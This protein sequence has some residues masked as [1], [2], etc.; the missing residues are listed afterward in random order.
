MN[1]LKN[2]I[3]KKIILSLALS[4]L[5]LISFA[6]KPHVN[7]V[8]VNTTNSTVKWTGSKI[9]D[10]HEGSINIKSGVLDFDHGLL[11]GGN[12][13]IDMN[14]ILCTDIESEKKN[15]YFVTHVKGE[16][17]FNVEKFPTAVLTITNAKKRDG[18]DYYIVADLTIKGK[19]HPIKFAAV[20]TANGLNFS[21]IANIKIDRTKWD[22]IYKSGNIF[23]DLLADNIILDEIEFDIFLLSVK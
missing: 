1:K 2:N 3:M 14:S 5:T 4:I 23:K 7:K 19:T 6:T 8:K 16:E 13:V 18:N 17:F 9:S 22:I 10:T 11:V 12:F 21:A 20:V 15:N